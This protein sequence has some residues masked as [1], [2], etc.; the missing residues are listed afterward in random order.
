LTGG[1]NGLAL[2]CAATDIP[3]ALIKTGR[4]TATGTRRAGG[5]LILAWAVGVTSGR[6]IT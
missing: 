5:A 6:A 3:L 1:G 2:G 4:A